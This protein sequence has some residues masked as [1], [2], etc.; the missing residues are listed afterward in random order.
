M[1]E[2]VKDLLE[3]MSLEVTVYDNDNYCGQGFDFDQFKQFAKLLIKDVIEDCVGH[4]ESTVIV[5]IIEQSE[6]KTKC[7]NSIKR[8]FGVE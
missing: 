6:T 5:D 1:N 2:L 8:H 7:I 3:R 4:L